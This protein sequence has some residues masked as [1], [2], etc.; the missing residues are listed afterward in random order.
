MRYSQKNSAY[1][2]V[3]FVLIIS[4]LLMPG[5]KAPTAA[6]AAEDKAGYEVT[7]AQG[8]VIKLAHKPNRIITMSLSTDEIILSMIEPERMAAL[9]YLSGD[10]G[11]STIADKAS[12]VSVRIKDYNAEALMA[13]HPDLII[14]PDWQKADVIQTLR[15]VGLPVFVCR[16]P[17]TVMEVKDTIRQIA[18]A[19]G[20]PQASEAIVAKMESDLSVIAA[21]VA[22][23]PPE[24]RQTVMLVS[25][26]ATY[27]GK[28]SLFDDMCRY[29]GLLN[30]SAVV[31][32]GKNDALSKEAIVKANPDLILM[33]T[34]NGGKIK[35]SELKEEFANDPSLQS[36]KA[37]QHKRLIQLPDQYLYSATQDI[38]KAIDDMAEAAYSMK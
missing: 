9:Y 18:L 19:I 15:D 23:I 13:L 24:K 17:A 20:E 12:R 10:P 7:D 35:V 34:W 27:G 37:I 2:L 26:M 6:L 11:I 8:T 25:H 1:Q 32:L 5:C 38:T 21:K 4:C 29:A 36:V 22:K 3:F 28:G 31:G 14:I 33:P 30:G 16:G